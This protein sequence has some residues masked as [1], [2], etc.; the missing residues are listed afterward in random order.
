MS[1]LRAWVLLMMMEPPSASLLSYF[2]LFLSRQVKNLQSL[3]QLAVHSSR[4]TTVAFVHLRLATCDTRWCGVVSA[5]VVEGFFL[6]LQWAI[7]FL[8]T[9]LDLTSPRSVVQLC[10]HYLKSS[11]QGHKRKTTIA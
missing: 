3:D 9:L 5:L 6:T 4:G 8:C 1:L 2:G 11:L 7:I 10:L